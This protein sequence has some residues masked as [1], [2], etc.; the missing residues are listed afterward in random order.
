M[1]GRINNKK[2]KQIILLFVGIIVFQA[3]I[4]ATFLLS[5]IKTDK[6]VEEED[7]D[8][9]YTEEKTIEIFESDGVNPNLTRTEY[10]FVLT[11]NATGGQTG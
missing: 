3:A 6:T 9:V 4:I 5:D 7:E 10:P 2:K 1:K 8:I 11:E